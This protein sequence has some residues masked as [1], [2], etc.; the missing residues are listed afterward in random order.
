MPVRYNASNLSCLL[1]VSTIAGLSWAGGDWTLAVYSLSFWHY[2]LYW[3]AYR[4]GAVIRALIYLQSDATYKVVFG[5]SKVEQAFV[6]YEFGLLDFYRELHWV[7]GEYNPAD[8]ERM[9][10]KC[11]YLIA[12]AGAGTLVR[13]VEAANTGVFYVVKAAME[14]SKS[15]ANPLQFAVG[16]LC[17][18]FRLMNNV[19]P[20]VPLL[21]LLLLAASLGAGVFSLVK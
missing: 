4:F 9:L 8:Q 18:L 12:P 1:F 3:L 16:A 15:P 19:H 10:L 11:N 17:N 14:Y 21:F 13:A 5:D 2:Y 20:F 6:T 7:E